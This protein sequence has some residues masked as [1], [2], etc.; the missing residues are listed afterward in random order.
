MTHAQ[1]NAVGLYHEL[2]GSGEPLVLVHGS[3]RTR[4]NGRW[5]SPG[6]AESFQVLVYDRRGHSRSERPRTPG[7]IGE[8]GAISPR[9]SR[10]GIRGGGQ[11]ARRATTASTT[12]ATARSHGPRA[13]AER[14]LPHSLS[15]LETRFRV[16]DRQ[17]AR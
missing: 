13:R 17:D 2:H 15:F 16:H 12:S 10:H 14:P 7:S 4:R 5:S 6:L 11:T 3:W 8:D 9:C 1:V